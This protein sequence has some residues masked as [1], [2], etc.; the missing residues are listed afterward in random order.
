[1]LYYI[2]SIIKVGNFMKKYSAKIENDMK[3][4]FNRLNEKDKR[5]YAAVEVN[6]LGHGGKKYIS[7][8]LG[9]TPK[10]ISKGQ[11]E[12]EELKKKLL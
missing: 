7:E 12:L 9:I 3:I 2:Y 4:V 10:T 11:L 8:L 5:R 1:M 6:K